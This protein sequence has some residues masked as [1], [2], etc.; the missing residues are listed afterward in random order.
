MTDIVDRLETVTRKFDRAVFIG[1]GEL[2]SMLTPSCGIGRIFSFDSAQGRL[3]NDRS[4]AAIADCEAPP[5]ARESVDLIVSV[6]TLH[7]AN[8]LISAL[9]QARFS[10]KPDG[11]FV[12]TLFGEQTLARL[13]QAL[14]QAETELTNGVSARVAPFAAI[15]SCG[16]ALTRAGFSL[17]VVDVDRLRVRYSAPLKLIA[18]LR[19]MGE[20]SALMS[21]ARPL[22]RDVIGRAMRI[23]SDQGGEELFDIVYMTGWAPHESQQK[24]LR[25][26]TAQMPLAKALKHRSA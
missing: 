6:L 18:D 23:F 7:S 10:L 9:G 22:R 2:I 5:L 11:L 17:P 3:P 26:G 19:G 4:L 21:R 15:Q 13:R 1:A 8:D 12:A 24:P 16:A 14:Y 20:T 25:P